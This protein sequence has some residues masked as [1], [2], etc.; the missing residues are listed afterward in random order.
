MFEPDVRMFQWQKVLKLKPR[1]PPNV[2]PRCSDWYSTTPGKRCLF[3]WL[4]AALKGGVALPIQ[5]PRCTCNVPGNDIDQHGAWRLVRAEIIHCLISSACTSIVTL[6]RFLIDKPCFQ[7]ETVYVWLNIAQ[8]CRASPWHVCVIPDDI[9]GENLKQMPQSNKFF[10]V[11]S[12]RL[13][14]EV[15]KRS[16][17]T[18]RQT[19]D[20][21]RLNN[22]RK[23]QHNALTIGEPVLQVAM[24]SLCDARGKYPLP[25]RLNSSST[26]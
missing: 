1:V 9:K 2:F 4:Q 25:W 19:F 21:M 13:F 5:V 11:I 7:F 14:F 16:Q 26:L 12:S 8:N 17:Q 10:A 23:E 22:P 18:S 3:A 24:T 20:V 15:R 6:L